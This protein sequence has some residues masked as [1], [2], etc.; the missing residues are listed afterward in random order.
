MDTTLLDKWFQDLHQSE[1]FV[2]MTFISSRII[3]EAVGTV[4]LKNHRVHT[5]KCHSVIMESKYWRLHT[6]HFK[7]CWMKHTTE[8]VTMIFRLLYHRNPFLRR[9][10]ACVL[11]A[12]CRFFGV[13]CKISQFIQSELTNCVLQ[14]WVIVHIQAALGY[15][16]S[17]KRNELK[18][19]GDIKNSK[20]DFLRTFQARMKWD[21]FLSAHRSYVAWSEFCEPGQ[22]PQHEDVSRRKS[23]N[24]VVL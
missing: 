22:T 18:W 9:F 6:K 12:N 14:R 20:F 17:R 4:T 7:R 23:F 10:P 19:N 1:L 16:L 3:W 5:S 24:L 15:V 11:S 2:N 13:A 21:H 8:R